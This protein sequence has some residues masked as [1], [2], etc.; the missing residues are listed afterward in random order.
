MRFFRFYNILVDYEEFIYIVE[1]IQQN[2][3]VGIVMFV[4]WS[5]L[6]FCK[7]LLKLFMKYGIGN[8]NDKIE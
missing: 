2:N 7:G 6:K 3:Y 4:L 5:K 8:I 1:R